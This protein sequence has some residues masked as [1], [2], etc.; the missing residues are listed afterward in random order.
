M[1]DIAEQHSFVFHNIDSEQRGNDPLRRTQI[2]E[3]IKRDGLWVPVNYSILS[4]DIFFWGGTMPG[5]ITVIAKTPH[6]KSREYDDASYSHP[7]PAWLRTRLLDPKGD[8]YPVDSS[9]IPSY[10]REI[11]EKD[12]R[13]KEKAKLGYKHIPPTNIAA[14][15]SWWGEGYEFS[16]GTNAALA[17]YMRGKISEYQAIR[18]I[19]QLGINIGV[20]PII[21]DE[22]FNI[23][24]I[25]AKIAASMTTHIMKERCEELIDA[26]RHLKSKDLYS[27]NFYLSHYYSD[28]EIGQKRNDTSGLITDTEILRSRLQERLG[29]LSNISS[30]LAQTKN[31]QAAYKRKITEQLETIN[32]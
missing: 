2:I 18:T 12:E 14:I 7:D 25:L 20:Q 30:S 16:R 27:V 4:S 21:L 10:V 19:R 1:I 23:D 24:K 26:I 6:E 29:A 3:K 13:G 9:E 28:I 22:T 31:A 32:S 5:S 15:I 17:S 8:I 11:Y